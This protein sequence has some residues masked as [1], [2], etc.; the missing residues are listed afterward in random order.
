MEHD[1]SP[2]DEF[3][4]YREA[5]GWSADYTAQRLGYRSR[6]SIRQIEAGEQ[7]PRPHDLAWLE[8]ASAYLR[9]HPAPAR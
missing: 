1:A 9:D 3:R 5:L 4:S 7:Q 2:A 8:A 6:T